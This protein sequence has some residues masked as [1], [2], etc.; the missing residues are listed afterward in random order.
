MGKFGCDGGFWRG[1]IDM[2]RCGGMLHGVK[3]V[4][5]NIIAFIRENVF[6]KYSAG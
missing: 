5:I 3:M 4:I 2:N 6:C 1:L